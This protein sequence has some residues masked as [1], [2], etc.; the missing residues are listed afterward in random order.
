MG[1]EQYQIYLQK[2]ILG[3]T[4]HFLQMHSG[5]LRH[6]N[7]FVWEY[8]DGAWRCLGMTWCCLEVSGWCV[9]VP[10][11]VSIPNPFAKDYVCSDIAFL[12]KPSSTKN[13]LCLR[14]SGWCLGGVWECLEGPTVILDAVNWVLMPKQV[15]QVQLV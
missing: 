8:L 6:K 3:H 2:V 5:P 11:D 7:V 13:C 4:L 14:V 12:P 1:M 10:G 9:G 15:I